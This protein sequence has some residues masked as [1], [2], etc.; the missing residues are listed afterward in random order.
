MTL[1]TPLKIQSVGKETYDLVKGKFTP[2]EAS[3][4]VHALFFKKISFHELK[5]FSNEIRY[6]LK[7][8]DSKKRIEELKKAQQQARDLIDKAK[9]EGKSLQLDSQISIKLV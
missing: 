1:K 2:D 5:I 9:E 4:I 7:D 8:H 6:G 3:E